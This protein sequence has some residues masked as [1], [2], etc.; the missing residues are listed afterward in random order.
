[1]KKNVLTA[2]MHSETV[3]DGYEE[4]VTV[5]LC[6]Q[7][8]AERELRQRGLTAESAG[9]TFVAAMAWAALAREGRIDV[10]FDEFTTRA[11]DI[12]RVEDAG[13]VDPTQS[14]ASTDSA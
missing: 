1:M 6:D 4:T 10:K 5:L 8:R 3:P 9:I 13:D 2:H 12:T 11:Y 14:A 7:I